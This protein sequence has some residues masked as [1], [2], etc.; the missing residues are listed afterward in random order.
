MRS[1]TSSKTSQGGRGGG[2]NP[3]N[4][5]PVSAYDVSPI[6]AR[7][8]SVQVVHIT[9]DGTVVIAVTFFFAMYDVNYVSH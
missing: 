2:Y 4:P 3:L 7:S 6:A 5:P 1:Q 9:S 8:V